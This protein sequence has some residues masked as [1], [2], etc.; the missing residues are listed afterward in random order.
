MG[1]TFISGFFLLAPVLVAIFFSHQVIK[2][3]KEPVCQKECRNGGRCIGP[4][5]CF[6]VDM[7]MVSDNV[8]DRTMV[9]DMTVV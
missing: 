1:K 8:V 7:A 2:S 5:R 6:F 4:N 3:F 9:V